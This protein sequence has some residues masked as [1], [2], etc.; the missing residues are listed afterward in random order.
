L[1]EYLAKFFEGSLAEL[2]IRHSEIDA[3]FRRIDTNHFSAAVYRSGTAETQCRIWLGGLGGSRISQIMYSSNEV[4][5]DNSFNEMMSVGEDRDSLFLHP[6]GG[7]T[8]RTVSNGGKLTM[9]GAAEYYWAMFVEPL[10]Q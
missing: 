4:G 3:A 1:L 2:K 6:M 7:Q 10:Q 8:H 5:T 9:Q